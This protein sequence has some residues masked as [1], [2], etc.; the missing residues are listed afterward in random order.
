MADKEELALMVIEN[1]M[2]LPFVKVNRTEFL[3]ATFQ[4]KMVNIQD[5]IDRG[6]QFFFSQQELDKVA[7][8]IINDTLLKSSGASFLSGIPGGLAMAAT[9]PADVAQFYAFS[10]RLAQQLSYIYGFKDLWSKDDSLTDDAKDTMILF[11]GVMLGV[12]SAGAT[13]RV[14]SGKLSAQLLKRLPQKALM[15]TFF[16]PILKKVLFVFGTKLTK[17]TFAKG[18]SKVVPVLGG[19]I[20]GTLNFSSLFPMAH[21]LQAELSKS[22]NYSDEDAVEDI[23]IINAVVNDYQDADSVSENKSADSS[24]NADNNF[25]DKNDVISKIERAH[26]L[27]SNGT[28]SQAEFDELKKR[29]LN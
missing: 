14:L 28:I 1:S 20:S 2:K 21:R 12:S 16:Y 22:I 27:L 26:D 15:K 11:L 6:P 29:I 9:I 25:T 24:K 5:L 13:I 8:R 23:K 4:E 7:D 17:Q 19:V 10:L 3:T 18:V